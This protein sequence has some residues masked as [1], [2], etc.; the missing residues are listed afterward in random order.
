MPKQTKGCS[1]ECIV[2]VRSKLEEIF[3]CGMKAVKLEDVI[4]FLI[5]LIQGWVPLAVRGSVSQSG[6][7]LVLN[8]MTMN[9]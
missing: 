7:R 4:W 1:I 8:L 3:S 9:A 2:Q 5:I 6:F